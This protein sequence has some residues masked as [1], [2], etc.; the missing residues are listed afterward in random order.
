VLIGTRSVALSEQVSDRLQVAGLPNTLL[1]ARQDQAEAAIVSQAGQ[2]GAITVATNMAGRGTDIPLGESAAMLGG[3]HVINAEINESRRVDRQLFGR[4]ARKGDPGSCQAILCLQDDLLER[5]L[6][7]VLVKVAGI[8]LKAL[9][10]PGEPLA[11]LVVRQGQRR[12]EHSHARLREKVRR[13]YATVRR[14]LSF[15]GEME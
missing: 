4:A 11:R 2:Q 5:A 6:P 8:V 10:W 13:H 3:L 9:R 1:N 12:C 14:Q 7:V 15:V